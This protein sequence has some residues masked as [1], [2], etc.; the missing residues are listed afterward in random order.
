MQGSVSKT[1]WLALI[2]LQKAFEKRGVGF[3]EFRALVMQELSSRS[4]GGGEETLRVESW[5]EAEEEMIGRKDQVRRER[6][7]EPG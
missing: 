7:V 1:F 6:H 4:E 3:D 5:R 2:G